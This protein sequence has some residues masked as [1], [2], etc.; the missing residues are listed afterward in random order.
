MSVQ[1]LSG[2]GAPEREGGREGEEERPLEHHRAA[3]NRRRQGEALSAGHQG[4]GVVHSPLTHPDS[5]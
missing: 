4:P 2:R 1:G 5:T 3:P